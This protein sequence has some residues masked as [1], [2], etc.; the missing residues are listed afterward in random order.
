MEMRVLSRIPWFW[1]GDGRW[2]WGAVN[3]NGLYTRRV[4]FGEGWSSLK[5]LADVN[6][7]ACSEWFVMRTWSLEERSGL[8]QEIGE[9]QLTRSWLN[10][11]SGWVCWRECVD[12]QRLRGDFGTINNRGS[13]R[14]WQRT[15]QGNKRL[16]IIMAW[17]KWRFV[18]RNRE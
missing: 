4:V 13:W 8:Q 1:L 9:W 10:V 14:R 16:H 15:G 6:V 3:L 18:L 12:E 17:K 11:G 2:L 5:Y 7:D